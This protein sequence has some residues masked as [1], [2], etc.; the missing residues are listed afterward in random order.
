AARSFGITRTPMSCGAHVS[1]SAV[2]QGRLDGS[3]P[4]RMTPPSMP[5]IAESSYAFSAEARLLPDWKRRI[6]VSPPIMLSAWPRP[7][8]SRPSTRIGNPPPLARQSAPTASTSGPSH[9]ARRGG[10]V[11]KSP[12]G[13]SETMRAKPNAPATRPSC[14]SARA[15]LFAMS[16]R[17]AGKAPPEKMLEKV[18]TQSRAVRDVTRPFMVNHCPVTSATT[19]RLDVQ[20]GVARMTFDRPE[21][22]IAGN[23]RFAAD[24]GRAVA[25]IDARA[26]VRVVVM[27]GAGRA[28]QTGVDL[29]ALAAGEL[30]QP[31]LVAWEDAMTAIERM[32]RLVIAGLNRPCIGGGPGL[33]PSPQ[34][35][36][37]G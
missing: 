18:I 20:G 6:T 9:T 27:T 11:R 1:R 36:A 12:R 23:A 17:T 34:L 30:T 31:D 16:G 14:Q 32:D 37:A 35:P 24:L 29:R 22:L 8:S 13:T 5:I 25:A 2:L 19:I 10:W 21:V 33:G 3:A 28:F 26:D 15:A 4:I 7:M